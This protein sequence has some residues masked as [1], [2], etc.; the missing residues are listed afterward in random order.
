MSY[1][2]EEHSIVHIS[3]LTSDKHLIDQLEKMH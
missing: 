2:D 1:R 3:E